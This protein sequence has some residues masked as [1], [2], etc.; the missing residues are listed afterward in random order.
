MV[1][2]WGGES[3]RGSERL[4]YPCLPITSWHLI[5]FKAHSLFI[6]LLFIY[7]LTIILFIVCVEHGVKGKNISFLAS[8][9]KK[10]LEKRVNGTS[11]MW[12]KA[13]QCCSALIWCQHYSH[14]LPVAF[15]FSFFSGAVIKF[16]DLKKHKAGRLYFNLEFQAT[17]HHFKKVTNVRAWDSWSHRITVKNREK[18]DYLL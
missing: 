9:N 10:V 16:S 14:D 3:I 8:V 6:H 5:T 2:S 18:R 7:W 1:S 12:Q 13:K 11:T 17:A 4:K 15:C